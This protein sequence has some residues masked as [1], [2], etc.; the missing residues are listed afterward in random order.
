MPIGVEWKVA[1]IGDEEIL[2][3]SSVTAQFHP[4]GRMTGMASVNNYTAAWIASD[5]RLLITDEAATRKAGPQPL[6][7]QEGKFL[8]MLPKI[9]SFVVREDGLSLITRDGVEIVLSK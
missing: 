6:M 5:G 7:E 2:N 8:G 1:A 3:G 9:N 4:D